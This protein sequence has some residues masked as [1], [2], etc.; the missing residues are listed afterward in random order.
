MVQAYLQRVIWMTNLNFVS[1]KASV[2]P[3][4][5]EVLDPLLVVMQSCGSTRCV[6]SGDMTRSGEDAS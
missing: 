2:C 4:S 6:D 1:D 3:F 5:I